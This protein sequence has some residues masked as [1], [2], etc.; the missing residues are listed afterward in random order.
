MVVCLDVHPDPNSRGATPAIL[1]NNL[2]VSTRPD[3]HVDRLEV[4]SSQY[5]QGMGDREVRDSKRESSCVLFS[6]K[7]G[8]PRTSTQVH[9][10]SDDK[11]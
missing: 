4:G 11:H 5:S 6:N 8:G 10:Q 7:K 9:S 2:V 3:P 1:D